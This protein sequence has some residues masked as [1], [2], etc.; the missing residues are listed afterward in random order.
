MPPVGAFVT[1]RP[2]RP[3]GATVRVTARLAVLGSQ[4]LRFAESVLT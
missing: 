2:E 4:S 3:V 1:A